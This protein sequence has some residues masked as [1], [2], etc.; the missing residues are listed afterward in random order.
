MSRQWSRLPERGTAFAVRLIRWIAVHIGRGP[1]RLLLYPIVAYF[2]PLTPPQRRASVDFLSRVFGRKPGWLEILR[3]YHCFAATILDRVYFLAGELKRFDIRV[4]GGQLL[5][6]QVDSGQGCI[7]L[8][9]HLGSFEALRAVG[10]TGCRFPLKIL[11]NVDHNERITTIT[12]AINPWM[13]T[14]VIPIRGP[15][16]LLKVRESLEQGYLIGTLGDRVVAGDKTV[17]CRFFGEPAS[18]PAGPLLLA[19]MVRCPVILV[20]A[21]YRGGNRYDLH[22]ELLTRELT[23][24]RGERQAAI[25]HWVQRYADRLEHYARRAP[26]N[27]FNFYDFWGKP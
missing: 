26:Y 6:D 14:T 23:A 5:L 24:G 4:N 12:N 1:G 17:H 11:M 2:V 18:F 8:G 7:L 21:L 16:T 22:F 27:W 10:V 9:S 3:H 13:E 25:Q 15:E 20:F 19:A